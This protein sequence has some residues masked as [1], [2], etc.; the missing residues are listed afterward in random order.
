MIYRFS[1]T[2]NGTETTV[3]EPK[4]WSDFKSEL[5]RD[6]KSHG[7]VFKFVSGT[8][9]LGFADGRDILEQA[10]QDK[11]VDAD[12]VF[13]AERANDAFSLYSLIF[14]GKAVMSSRELDESY[15]NVSFEDSTFQQK[16][17]NRLNSKVRLDAT[18]DL[19]GNALSD[20]LLS[21]TNTW[22]S[23][24]FYEDFYAN[25]KQNPLDT[26]S[27][28]FSDTNAFSGGGSDYSHVVVN[29][30]GILV[31][32]Y[33]ER[34][35]VTEALSFGQI[36]SGSGNQNLVSSVSGDFVLFSTELKYQWAGTFTTAI[37]GVNTL[38]ARWKLRREDSDGV[39]VSEDTV[40]TKILQSASSPYVFDTG[41]LTES[42][43]EKA[44]S[45]NAGDRIFF[46]LE[47][48]YNTQV[49]AGSSSTLSDYKLFHNSQLKYNVLIDSL[50][51][52]VKFSPIFNVLQKALSIISGDED[53]LVSD[54]LNITENGALEDGCG[55][56]F[57]ITN[58]SQIRGINNPIEI[59]TSEILDSINAIFGTGWGFE[60]QYDGSYKVRLELMEYFYQDAE[61]LDL[62][63]PINAD[64]SYMESFETEL[65]FN[66]V[67]IGYNK[68]SDDEQ[69][70]GDLE[71]FLTE[72]EYA[73]PLSSVKG[74]Y[75]K[76]SSLIASGRLIQATISNSLTVKG[77][78][79]KSW[80]F[81]NNNFIISVVRDATNFIPENDEYFESLGGI[82]DPTTVYNIRLAPVY[83]ELNHSLIV[84]SALFGQEFTNSVKNTSVEINK[85]FNATFSSYEECL[86]GDEQR[87]QRS[88]IGNIEIGDNYSGLRIFKPSRHKVK[89]AMTNDQYSLIIDSMEGNNSNSL[90]NHG[91]ISYRDNEGNIQKGFVMKIIW[92]YINGIGEVETLEKADN[93]GI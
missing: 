24:R 68:F 15:F 14:E 34:Q 7:V 52:P 22:N 28:T 61:I 58:G 66:K 63:S 67:I 21:Y 2:Y 90:L 13:M 3:I 48:E 37:A 43:T 88:S 39:F 55:G 44:I 30:D 1:L 18:E 20:T 77:D 70:S 4:G 87:L 45:V 73:L 72:S 54:F 23:E 19:D 76:T 5:K 31:N 79:N 12:V 49:G 29:F 46:Y 8:L 85:D 9:K 25:Y 53:A 69:Y 16:V 65:I 92:D 11:G 86:L 71:D 27:T 50:Q 83:M 74:E 64:N 35:I 84:N 89:L 38:T 82:D 75:K 26:D 6:F 62:G 33:E 81:D 56:K 17:V 47:I 57:M 60:K 59:K 40:H 80:K 36:G 10:F 51:T 42:T 91:Y 78:N 93:Y 32:E 41:E